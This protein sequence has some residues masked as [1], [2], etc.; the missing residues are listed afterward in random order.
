MLTWALTDF[1][2]NNGVL[3]TNGFDAL[4]VLIQTN[5][6]RILNK[7]QKILLISDTIDELLDKMEKY[8]A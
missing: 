1:I 5:E 8:Q 3:N 6:Q 7:Q 4:L 2:K